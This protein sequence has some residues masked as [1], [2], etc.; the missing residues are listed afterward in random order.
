MYNLENPVFRHFGICAMA[1]LAKMLVMSL[2]TS[3]KR[4]KNGKFANREDA[5]YGWK[6]SDT[7][8]LISEKANPIDIKV[9]TY[10]IELNC[11]NLMLQ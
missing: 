6:K 2:L 8:N 5:T 11:Y 1:V 3:S 7:K 10:K 4:I 9:Q